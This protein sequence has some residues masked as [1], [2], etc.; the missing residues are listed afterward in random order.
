MTDDTESFFDGAI[1]PFTKYSGLY[2]A[3]AFVFCC[4]AVYWRWRFA[5]PCS[6]HANRLAIPETI[7]NSYP[8]KPLTRKKNNH[9]T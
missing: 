9:S 6:V 3:R 1:V 4:F 8:E 7:Y 5:K 2:L